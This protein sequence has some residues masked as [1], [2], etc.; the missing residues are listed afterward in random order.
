M[1]NADD[2]IVCKVA[3]KHDLR[4]YLLLFQL[5]LYQFCS[6]DGIAVILRPDKSSSVPSYEIA[7]CCPP[8]S[9]FDEHE[10]FEGTLLPD[11]AD[12]GNK[13]ECLEYKSL[14]TGFPAQLEPGGLEHV[15]LCCP[16]LPG[17]ESLRDR[18]PQAWRH[19][20]P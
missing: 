11:L 6:L 18:A 12:D 4:T 19:N 3:P 13:L 5:L 7:T 17:T 2:A 9:T 10:V 16:A 20:L 15:E 14:L 8:Q 1:L